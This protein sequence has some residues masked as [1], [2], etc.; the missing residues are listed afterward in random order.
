M[1]HSRFVSSLIVNKIKT[2]GEAFAVLT[3]GVQPLF[4]PSGKHR[5]KRFLIKLVQKA[6]DGT[7]ELVLVTKTCPAY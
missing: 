7:K 4:L 2:W 5:Y 1:P 3:S 6:W